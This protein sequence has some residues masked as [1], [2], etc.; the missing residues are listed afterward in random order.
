MIERDEAR[1]NLVE[2]PTRSANRAR[3]FAHAVAPCARRP[4]NNVLHRR[5]SGARPAGL[6]RLSRHGAKPRE[7]LVRP[8]ALRSAGISKHTVVQAAAATTASGGRG[9]LEQG[10]RRCDLTTH[11]G[12]CTTSTGHQAPNLDDAHGAQHD[13]QLGLAHF[14]FGTAKASRYIRL[15]GVFPN[16]WRASRSVTSALR[17][18]PRRMQ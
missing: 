6:R 17:R 14:P 4:G 10:A 15:H 5:K 12:K 16:R 3:S 1:S 8:W 13:A 11:R 2:T 7:P 9:E 18:S